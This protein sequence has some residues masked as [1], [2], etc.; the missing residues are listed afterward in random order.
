MLTLPHGWTGAVS[1]RLFRLALG[2]R[3]PLTNGVTTVRGIDRPIRIRRDRFHVPHVDAETARDGWFALGFC[4]GQDRA[5]QIE[6]YA[7]V[8]SGRLAELVGTDGVAIDRLSRRLGFRRTAGAQ[9]RALDDDIRDAVLAFARGVSEGMT[10][11][12]PVAAHEYTLLRSEPTAITGVDVVAILAMNAF[13]L[14]G[15]WESELGRLQ[16][17]LHDGPEALEALDAVPPSHLPATSPVGEAAG[18][19][20]DRLADDLASLRDHVLTSGGSNNWA[21]AAR[22]TASGRPLVANDPHLPP[23]LPPFWYLAHLRTPDWSVAGAAFVGTPG[24]AAGHN[25]HG[26]WGIT[27]AHSD[28]TDLVIEEVTGPGT[29]RGVDGDERCEI[30]REVIEVRGGEPVTEEVL[31]TPRGP[32]VSPALS[33]EL[34]DARVALSVL[35]TWRDARPVRGL[36]DIVTARSLDDLRERFTSWPSLPLNLVWADTSGTIGWQVVGDVP[37]RLSERGASLPQPAWLDTTGWTGEWIGGDRLPGGA[38][39]DEGY[40]ATANNRPVAD[41]D[42]DA[43]FLGVDFLDGYRLKA[44][45]DALGAREDWDVA[46]T[47]DL[48]VDTRSPVW[49]EV[50]EA[51]TEVDPTDDDARYARDRLV[52]WDGRVRADSTGAAVFELTMAALVR[53]VAESRAPRAS[54]WIVGERFTELSA[55]S[56]LALKRTGHLVR[57]L[58]EQPDGWFDEGW[59]AVIGGALRE[60]VATLRERAGDDPSR[61]HWGDVRT[62]TLRHL[63]SRS[64][65]ALAGIFDRGPF[66]WGGD[67]HTIPQASV[68]P[69]D[70]L[71]DPVAIASLRMVVDV[72]AWSAS[73]WVLPGGQSG[74]PLSPHY[75]DQLPRW[76]NAAGIPIPWTEPEVAAATVG[77][78]RLIPT[79]D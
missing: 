13:L 67:T 65:P 24:I 44:I 23:G 54:H 40:V 1:R 45:V 43:P 22:R 63:V 11:G 72:G 61:W 78:L 74:N 48:Q 14:A 6:T 30:R 27:A 4:Q 37:V 57:L 47:L 55:H 56:L 38:D 5:F 2:D 68:P 59:E 31:I 75:D 58:R 16:V 42:D 52:G 36:L 66:P 35:G 33:G 15:N 10:T 64:A 21:L 8:A 62:L 79:S 70:P 39:P 34:P 73:R 51:L 7:R 28:T 29:V 26:S 49:P 18:E 25:G 19:M 50:R 3:L 20:V 9:L 32:I 53:R 71:G 76:R 41:G 69:L 46:K 17:L 12:S 77:D 60:A